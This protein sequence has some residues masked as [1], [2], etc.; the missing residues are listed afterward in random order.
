MSS[1][2]LTLVSDLSSPTGETFSTKL[3]GAG[4]HRKFDNLHTAQYLVSNFSGS[5]KLQATLEMFPGEADWFDI[6]GTAFTGDGSSNPDPVNFRGNF[7]WIRAVYALESGS[8][9]SIRYSY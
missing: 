9:S 2:I 3:K 7:M 5:I 4:Y 1:E 8:I 6:E